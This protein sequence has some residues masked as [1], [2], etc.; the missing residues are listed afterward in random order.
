MTERGQL[1]E[2]LSREEYTAYRKEPGFSL[3][4]WIVEQL[5]RLLAAIFPDLKPGPGTISLLSIL[6]VVALAAFLGWMGWLLLRRFGPA[7]RLRSGVWMEAGDD[8]RSWRHYARL[9]EGFAERGQWRDGVRAVFLAFLFRLEERGEL[10][11]EAWKTNREY[12]EELAAAGSAHAPALRGAMGL[13]ERVWY[14]RL[15][16]SQAQYDE[17]K[18][19]LAEAE[20]KEVP[21]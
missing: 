20:G 5:G 18:A 12:L 10:R 11:V 21:Q 19:L 2:I 14:G 9:G 13:F 7:G 4:D 16:A 15:E 1:E 6:I 17:L 8:S 3:W